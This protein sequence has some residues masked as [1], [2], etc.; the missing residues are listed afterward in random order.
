MPAA[1]RS[2]LSAGPDVGR[3]RD[4]AAAVAAEFRQ[5]LGG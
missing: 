4:N 1:S 2:L 3:L 5:V